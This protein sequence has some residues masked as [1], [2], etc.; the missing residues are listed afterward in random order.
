MMLKIGKFD[1][2]EEAINLL[3]ENEQTE[4][5][6]SSAV[7]QAAR[8]QQHSAQF[9]QFRNQNGNQQINRYNTHR[10]QFQ[11]RTGQRPFRFQST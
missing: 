11:P 2:L 9:P 10:N 8:M 4:K 3:I 7:L 6:Q 5:N 1:S